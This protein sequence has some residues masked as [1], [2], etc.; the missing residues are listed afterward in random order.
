VRTYR[1]L[2]AAGDYHR[3]ANYGGR[4]ADGLRTAFSSRGLPLHVN[5]LGSMLQLFTTDAPADFERFGALDPEPLFYFYL[6]L[7]NEGVLLS[8]PT[9]NHIYLSFVHTDRDL[10]QILTKVGEV[11]DRYDFH[12]FVATRGRAA[13]PPDGKPH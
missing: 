9:S 13:A 6:A 4:L 10:E 8:L 12:T 1:A 7:I 5:Q 3:L 11:L 2:D